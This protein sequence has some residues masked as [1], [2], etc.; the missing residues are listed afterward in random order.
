MGY[1]IKVSKLKTEAGSFTS[2]TG[3]KK[4]KFLHFKTMAGYLAERE[5]TL[6]ESEE[7]TLFDAYISFIDEGP[8][9]C[10]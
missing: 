7:R 10:T 5:K 1:K 8:T 2:H 6:P 4:I 3:R 9:I